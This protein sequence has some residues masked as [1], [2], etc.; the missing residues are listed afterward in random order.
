MAAG[1]AG[2]AE[3]S[4]LVSG[5]FSQLMAKADTMV[6]SAIRMVFIGSFPFGVG[7]NGVNRLTIPSSEQ[8]GKPDPV[9]F[10]P[11]SLSVMIPPEFQDAG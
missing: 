11:I 9:A 8:F 1:V 3:P 2:A 10:W 7:F 5:A 4:G 6:A